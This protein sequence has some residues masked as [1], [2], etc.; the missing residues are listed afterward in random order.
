MFVLPTHQNFWNGGRVLLL[1][2]RFPYLLFWRE[3]YPQTF[4]SEFLLICEYNSWKKKPVSYRPFKSGRFVRVCTENMMDNQYGETAQETY[5]QTISRWELMLNALQINQNNY[6]LSTFPSSN[7]RNFE[8]S[9]KVFLYLNFI[10]V[11]Q[12]S[13]TSPRL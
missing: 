11:L 2:R 8:D 4:S 1:L 9:G 5:I 12:F 13:S 10:R 7:R 3:T 6:T